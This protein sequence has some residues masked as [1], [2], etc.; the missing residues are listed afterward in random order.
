MTHAAEGEATHSGTMTTR[1]HVGRATGASAISLR[2]MEFAQGR[3]PDWVN[4]ACDDVLYVVA[5]RGTI[6]LDGR[7]FEIA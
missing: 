7:P 6:Y 5:G 4:P 2:T 1:R 3:S